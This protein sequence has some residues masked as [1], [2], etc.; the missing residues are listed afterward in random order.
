MRRASSRVAPAAGNPNAHPAGRPAAAASRDGSQCR[1]NPSAPPGL[2]KTL[3][4]LLSK[5]WALVMPESLFY[6]DAEI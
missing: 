1:A 2:H 6:A 5:S 3:E 4:R